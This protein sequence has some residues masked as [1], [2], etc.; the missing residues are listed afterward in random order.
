M[1]AT[2]LAAIAFPQI[3]GLFNQSSPDWMTNYGAFLP[4]LPIEEPTKSLHFF[5]NGVQAFRMDGIRDLR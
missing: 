2:S 3:Y 1:I 5:W 4:N